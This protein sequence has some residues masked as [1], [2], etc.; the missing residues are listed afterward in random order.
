MQ[1]TL[2]PEPLSIGARVRM[3]ETLRVLYLET[4]TPDAGA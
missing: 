3:L 2:R 1:R 4:V